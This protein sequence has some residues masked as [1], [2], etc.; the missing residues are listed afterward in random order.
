[1]RFIGLML[2][3]FFVGLATLQT[4][5]QPLETPYLYYY[6]TDAG[7]IAVNWPMAMIGM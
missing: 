6:D 2:V 1:M 5:A 3:L 7:G 4:Q